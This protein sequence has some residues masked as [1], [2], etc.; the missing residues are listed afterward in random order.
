MLI[1]IAVT[2]SFTS[3]TESSCMAALENKETYPVIHFYPK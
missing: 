3:R 2:V 1:S